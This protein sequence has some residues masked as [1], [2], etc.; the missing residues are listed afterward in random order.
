MVTPATASCF[1][2]VEDL[3]MMIGAES[4]EGSLKQQQGAVCY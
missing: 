3:L 2:D 4:S 1:D